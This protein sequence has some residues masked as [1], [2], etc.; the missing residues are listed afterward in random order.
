M[1]SAAPFNIYFDQS[2]NL[3]IISFASGKYFGFLFFAKTVSLR[4]S[5]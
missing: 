1:S 2:Q 3:S 5:F 4:Y